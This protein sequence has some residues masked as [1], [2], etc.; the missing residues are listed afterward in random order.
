MGFKLFGQMEL[1]AFWEEVMNRLKS[2]KK[3]V[4]KIV[5]RL[6][7]KHGKDHV[8]KNWNHFKR[9]VS[10]DICEH[11]SSDD[12]QFY[13]RA[14]R[15]IRG[16]DKLQERLTFK[17]QIDNLNWRGKV[18]IVYGGVDCD[19]STWDNRVALIDANVTSVN[20]WENDYMEYAEGSQW[21]NIEPMDYALSLKRSSRDLAME[22]FEDGHPHVIYG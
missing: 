14:K 19:H 21:W 1:K 8:L 16:T 12:T 9:H 20:G 4:G 3:E 15:K 18:A 2:I 5:P 13:L 17:N 6:I 10:L 7:E 22:A 11:L